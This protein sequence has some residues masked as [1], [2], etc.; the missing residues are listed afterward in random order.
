MDVRRVE[1]ISAQLEEASSTGGCDEFRMGIVLTSVTMIIQ[2]PE[3]FT[4]AMV[5]FMTSFEDFQSLDK[6]VGNY[7]C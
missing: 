2:N 5:S 7:S 1:S 3:I 6:A 4:K